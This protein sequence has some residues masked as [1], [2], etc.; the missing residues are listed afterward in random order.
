MNNIN[1]NTS[2]NL[3][4]LQLEYKNL[5]MRY[6]Q[7]V[8][9]YRNI[10]LQNNNDL[11]NVRGSQFYGTGRLDLI[12]STT[13]G[14]CKSAC[15]ANRLCS[16]ATYNT[17]NNSCELRR[18][19]G[20]IISSN[21]NFYAIIPKSKILLR[22]IQTINQQLINKNREIQ[23]NLNRIKISDSVSNNNLAERNL[24]SGYSNLL[25]E[26]QYINNILDEYESLDAVNEDSIKRSTQNYYVYI[27]LSV[28]VFLCVLF[29]ILPLL[30]SVS[31]INTS[32]MS[33]ISS[34]DT[35]AQENFYSIILILIAVPITYF[36]LKRM[37]NKIDSKF[38]DKYINK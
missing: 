36:L 25:L 23:L 37:F 13:L 31:T 10:Y 19:N 26:K 11:D 32:A 30:P 22:D 15:K 16:G 5:L 38:A 33:L 34:I 14:A 27:L 17:T 4:V 35:S 8:S 18:G 9:D 24:N 3:E 21:N 6:N 1:T 2:V 12:N 28:L 29:L 7:L 20:D